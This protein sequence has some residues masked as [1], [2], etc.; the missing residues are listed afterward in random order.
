MGRIYSLRL[1]PVRSARPVRHAPLA[2]V[3]ETLPEPA[4]EPVIEAVP[5][6]AAEPVN[7]FLLHKPELVAL[8]EERGLDA[9]GTRAEIL[10]RLAKHG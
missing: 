1:R 3:P 6:S 8:A 7:L 2:R 4:P 9:T 10:G 5:E